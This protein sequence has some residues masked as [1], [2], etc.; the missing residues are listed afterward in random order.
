MRFYPDIPHRRNRAIAA[1]VAVLLAL[2]V[3]AWLAFE[4]H[5]AVDEL[6]GLGRGVRDAGTAVE[7]GFRAAA[8]SV[9]GAPLVGGDLAQGLRDAGR[10]SGGRAE[11]AGRSGEDAVHDLADLLGA[12]TFL[13]PAA[14]LLQ[15]FLPDRIAAVRRLTAARR[16]LQDAHLPERRRLIA[17][18]AA[19]SLPYATLLRH[20][21]D[22]FGDLAAGRYDGLV[23]AALADAGLNT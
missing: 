4:V 1:D 19:F 23:E 10:G 7:G 8:E 16:V 6:A 2:L 18:R 17:M 9:E 15:R 12:L 22:P 3:F 11:S 5:D 14:L 13:I 20:T 21:A